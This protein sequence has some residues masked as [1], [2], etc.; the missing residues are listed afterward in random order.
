MLIGTRSRGLLGRVHTS[1][2][3]NCVYSLTRDSLFAV[4][5][6]QSRV[7]IGLPNRLAKMPLAPSGRNERSRCPLQALVGEPLWKAE[8]RRTELQQSRTEVRHFF[9]GGLRPIRISARLAS[10]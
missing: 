2:D 4:A 8:A 3:S 9:F 7:P 5:A 6:D 10:P 1:D